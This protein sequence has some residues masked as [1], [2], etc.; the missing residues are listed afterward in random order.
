MFQN[1]FPIQK[2]LFFTWYPKIPFLMSPFSNVL[3]NWG[4]SWNIKTYILM[5]KHLKRFPK[6]PCF[7]K[8]DNQLGMEGVYIWHG[9]PDGSTH[10][11]SN[12]PAK[13]L[14]SSG[15]TRYTISHELTTP[16]LFGRWLGFCNS[17]SHIDLPPYKL[18]NILQSTMINY[19]NYYSQ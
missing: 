16:V 7:F 18:M 9:S 11:F 2:A 3:Y 10:A 1:Y 14:C 4:Q 8:D 15:S 5:W 13:F 12:M 19:F 6:K 17:V